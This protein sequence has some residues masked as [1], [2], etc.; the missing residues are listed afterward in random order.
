M[1]L[2]KRIISAVLALALLCG[3]VPAMATEDSGDTT[4]QVQTTQETQTGEASSQTDNASTTDEGA[5]DAKTTDG[6]A[7]STE[8][9]QDDESVAEQESDASSLTFAFP[10][11]EGHWAEGYLQQAVSLGLLAGSDGYILPNKEVKVSEAI[12][13]LNRSLGGQNAANVS[14]MPGLDKNAWYANEI[15]KGCYLGLVD[16][17]DTRSFTANATRAE[18][19]VL[20]GRAFGFGE[21]EADATVLSKFSDAETLSG[22]AQR[23]TAALVQAGIVEGNEYG[24]LRPDGAL[25]RAAFVTMLLRIASNYPTEADNLATVSGGAVI[26][27]AQA[28]LTSYPTGDRIFATNTQAATLSHVTATDRIVFKGMEHA[29]VSLED[30]S[31]LSYLALDPAGSIDVTLDETSKVQTLVVAGKGGNVTLAG[32]VGILHITASGRVINL[33][34]MNASKIVVS[35]SDNTI[36]MN[37]V[38]RNVKLLSGAKNTSLT[39]SADVGDIVVAARD[40][41]IYGDVTAQSVIVTAVNCMIAPQTDNY[42]ESIDQ[43]LSGISLNMGVPTKVTAG[44]SLTTQITLSGVS[45]NKVGVG[46]W[47]KNG[48]KIS[49]YRNESFAISSDTVSKIVTE[50]TFT[51]DMATSVTMGFEL[52]YE[53]PSSGETERLYIEKTV[54]IENYSDEWYYQRDVDRVLGLVSS[55]YSGNYTTKYA[56]DNDYQSYEKEVFVNAKGYSSNSEYLVWINRGMQHVNVFTGSKGNW[57]LHKSFLVGTGASESQTPTGITTIS[58]KLAAGWTTSTYTVKPVV[59]FY[60]GTGYAFHSRLFYPNTTTLMDGSI[61]YPISHGCVRMYDADVQWIYDTVPIGSTVVIF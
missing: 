29:S 57:T 55:T 26:R 10:D 59:G 36:I 5:S 9:Q 13:I 23:A 42:T 18:A 50:F 32:E 14:T 58:Y 39:L 47:Y 56:T 48:E 45:A 49:G 30:S 33:S 61:G 21:A 25:T 11:I 2:G 27:T 53:N 17:T 44:G 34:G 4:E 40:C 38:V 60:P 19:F 1:F 46:Q 12:T 8:T 3:I 37:G 31:T 41:K 24:E 51:K 52:L 16:V 22:E 20:I 15:A 6:D 28:E 35:G 43:G 7:Q 54:P